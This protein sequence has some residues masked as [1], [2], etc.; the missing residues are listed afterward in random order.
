MKESA[1]ISLKKQHPV[2][3]DTTSTK[4]MATVKTASM[5]KGGV[6][7]TKGSKM[8]GTPGKS[9]T[10]RKREIK[11]KSKQKGK[12]DTMAQPAADK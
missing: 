2:L 12:L 5:Q 4:S 3:S 7:T 6:G 11:A 10:P 8:K 1:K 9:A